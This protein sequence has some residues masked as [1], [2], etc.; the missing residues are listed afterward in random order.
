V[1]ILQVIVECV[2]VDS[3]GQNMARESGLTMLVC[4][5][6]RNNMIHHAYNQGVFLSITTNAMSGFSSKIQEEVLQMGGMDFQSPTRQQ[7][8]LIKSVV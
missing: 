2:V 7:Y 5:P 6:V 8:N 1:D 4:Y 3:G